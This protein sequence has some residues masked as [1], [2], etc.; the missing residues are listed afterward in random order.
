MKAEWL[1]KTKSK[2]KDQNLSFISAK[3]NRKSDL[4]LISCVPSRVNKEPTTNIKSR[5]NNEKSLVLLFD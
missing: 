3:A 5:N 4:S 2:Y 1:F